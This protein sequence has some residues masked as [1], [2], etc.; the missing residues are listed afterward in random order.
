MYIGTTL[1]A[2]WL[3]IGSNLYPVRGSRSGL[4]YNEPGR[5]E[6]VLRSADDYSQGSNCNRTAAPR[7][8]MRAL[9]RLVRSILPARVHGALRRMV[10]T[11]RLNRLPVMAVD[12]APLPR[13]AEISFSD[14]LWGNGMADGWEQAKSSIDDV[15]E[16]APQTHATDPESGRAIY[17]LISRL[18]PSSILEIGTNCGASTVYA[19]MAMRE[20]RNVGRPP[21]WSPWT[22]LTSTIPP[23]P[24]QNGTASPFRPGKILARLDCADMVEFSIA[25]IHRLS[26]R[27]QSGVRFHLL[28]SRPLRGHRLP[29]IALAIGALRPG[30]T[31]VASFLLSGHQTLGYG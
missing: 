13:A 28:G 25:P 4:V 22:C 30:R 1:L 27:A 31:T 17:H 16:Y 8:D 3:P 29:D 7:V 20:Y 19:A 5:Q 6:D 18:Q 15:F 2:A 21:V 26:E 24:R 14:M 11:R 10:Y 9:K 12:V 23:P